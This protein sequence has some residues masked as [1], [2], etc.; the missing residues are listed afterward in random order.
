LQRGKNKTLQSLFRLT[1]LLGRTMDLSVETQVFMTWLIEE[2]KPERSALFMVD[3]KK[4]EFLL[5]HSCGFKLEEG[6]SFPIGIDIWHWLEERGALILKEKDPRRYIVPMMIEDQLIGVICMVSASKS[7]E[8]IRE[9]HFLLET[10]SGF[11]A[12]VIRNIWRYSRVEKEVEERTASL[13]EAKRRLE[14]EIAEKNAIEGKL[15]EER[16]ILRSLIDSALDYIYIKDQ[17]SQFLVA[18][19]G[20]AYL[21]GVNEPEQLIGK[22]DFDFYPERL[23]KRYFAD[24]QEIIKTGKPVIAREEPLLDLRSGR[25]GCQLT[26]KVPLRNKEGKIIGIV[27]IGRDITELKQFEDKLIEDKRV[28][29][30]IMETAPV[31]IVLTDPEGRIIL[32][33]KACEE[34]TGYTHEEVKGKSI[35]ELFLPEE[36]VSVV[37]ERFSN[38]LNPELL[39]P[40]QNPWI[41]S[42]GEKRLIEWR[43][44]PIELSGYVKPC[45]LGVGTDITEH[46][47][48][49]EQFL[50]AQ[51]MEAIGRLAGGVAHDFNNMLT[52]ILG[53]AQLAMEMLERENQIY[54]YIKEIAKAGERASSL[55]R[56]LLAFSRRQILQ[57]QNLDLNNLISNLE[58]MLKRL[59]GEDIELVIV[60]GSDIGCIRADPGQL[61]QVI[62]NLVVNARDAMPGGG[63]LTIETLNVYLDEAYLKTHAGVKPGNYV[64][65][66]VSDTGI[67]MNK[68]VLS[69]M[70]EPFFTT[71]EV[72]KGTGL[73]LSTVYG[74]V[75]Q[76]GGNI[77]VYSEPGKGSTFKIYL[78]V[79]EEMVGTVREEEAQAKDIHGNETVLVIEDDDQ[80]REIARGSL[81]SYGYNVILAGKSEEA[82]S[83]SSGYNGFIHIAVIDVVMPGMN[84]QELAEK[85][86]LQRPQMKVLYMSGYTD[87]TIV[88]YGVLERGVPFI[89]KPFS[90]EKL[91]EKVRE[92]LDSE[93]YHN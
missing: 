75:K 14:A 56:Q 65:L 88:H 48:L 44:A 30:A 55:T 52:A 20:V 24:E 57:P 70:F 41:T 33:N 59:I 46:K 68:E 7:V 16:N 77:W 23:A 71:K 5:L 29:E 1:T 90:P 80:V 6:L 63:K 37:K 73:G 74:I 69:H 58:K 34:L 3:E 51:K 8:S 60:P 82:L 92:V 78:P 72:G 11:L 27:G 36:W 53:Y 2:V 66:A 67:G 61:E 81:S 86:R 4:K 28:I 18:N 85:L 10:A 89:Q 54:S 43:C 45:I 9:E 76:S 39:K 62:M 87:N 13:N 22:T 31:L 19:K 84:G 91:V 50:Q 83:I 79:V 49:E 35:S 47:Q 64:M 42:S 15:Q 26:T 25:E 93:D 40:H 32:I 38:P 12:P 21:M 17:E